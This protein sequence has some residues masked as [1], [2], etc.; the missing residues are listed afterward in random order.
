MIRI[1]YVDTASTGGTMEVPGAEGVLRAERH[2]PHGVVVKLD[3]PQ[4]SIP[5]GSLADVGRFFLAAAVALG[6]DIS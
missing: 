5:A 4:L 6:Q 2:D 3:P 1:C